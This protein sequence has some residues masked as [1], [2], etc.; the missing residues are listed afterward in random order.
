M[1]ASDPVTAHGWTTNDWRGDLIFTTHDF[2]HS[3][4][5]EVAS[6]IGPSS[7]GAINARADLARCI[8][9]AALLAKV[10]DLAAAGAVGARGSQMTCS[11]SRF[12][13]SG[14]APGCRLGALLALLTGDGTP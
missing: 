14:H 9:D 3:N 4:G 5:T 8:E 13:D 12:R 2:T 7:Q 1:T 11:C 10:R 6:F